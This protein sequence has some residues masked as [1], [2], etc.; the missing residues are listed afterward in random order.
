MHMN[1]NE[2]VLL[3]ITYITY[4]HSAPKASRS[5]TLRSILII[6][7]TVAA[8]FPDIETLPALSAPKYP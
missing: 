5:L 2:I 7:F 8:N 3:P 1:K 6:V 4:I